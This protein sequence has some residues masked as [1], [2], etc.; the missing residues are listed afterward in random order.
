MGFLTTCGSWA[1][2]WTAG[3]VS[4]ISPVSGR[5]LCFTQ[6]WP[7]FSQHVV[8]SVAMHSDVTQDGGQVLAL[9]LAALCP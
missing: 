8:G 1:S 7:C 9:Q 5:S 6:Y 2:N 4:G 3:C